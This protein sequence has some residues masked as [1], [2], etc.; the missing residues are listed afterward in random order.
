MALF[1]F[2][3][4]TT[5]YGQFYYTSENDTVTIRG[6]YGPGGDIVIPETID[7]MPVTGIGDW[8]FRFITTESAITIPDTVTTIGSFAFAYS[9][10]ITSCPVPKSVTSLGSIPFYY[11]TRLPA[12]QVDPLNPNYSS[13][14]GVLFNK[15]QTTL[16]QFPA[17]KGGSYSLPVTATT[18]G[19]MAFYHCTNVASVALPDSLTVISSDAFQ[20]CSSLTAITASPLN[21][22]FSSV[23]GV[24]FNKT[25]DTLIRFPPGKHGSYAI[26]NNVTNI[27]YGAF[28]TSSSLLE[29][30]IPESVATIE[31]LAFYKCSA[32]T[33]FTVAE[34]NEYYSSLNGVLFN[35]PQTTLLQYPGGRTNNYTVPATVTTIGTNAFRFCNLTSVSLANVTNIAYQAFE[36]CKS[37]TNLSLGN[38]IQ[39]IEDYAFFECY[40]LASITFPESITNLGAFA[41][42]NCTN[43]TSAFFQGNAP[44]AGG[45][46][47]SDSPVTVY[48]L[49]GT[50]GWSNNFAARPAELWN[51]EI[52][53]ADPAFGI[54]TPGFGLSITGTTNIPIVIEAATNLNAA[55]TALQ[56]CILTN[57]SIYFT[58]ANWT[59]HP[60]RY[61]RIRSP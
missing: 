5:V 36:S 33:N 35:K 29:I 11:C 18:I 4:V 54:E 38:S 17:G 48:Y 39:T 40:G 32:L 45:G 44:S 16:I 12:I 28:A 10:G 53:V 19:D 42:Y 41:F 46:A 47:F 6:Y 59:N 43:L 56:S 51:P 27:G 34:N 26:P 7:N 22:T 61:Y 1:L 50:T 21:P 31:A 3:F 55:W 60:A 2:A 14:Q 37:L 9:T 58:D 24:L 20:H 15:N 13:H 57:G 8:C 25:E 52:T 49:P 23:N 30:G